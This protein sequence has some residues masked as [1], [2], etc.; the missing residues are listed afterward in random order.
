VSRC[1]NTRADTTYSITFVGAGKQDR[2]DFQAKG[3]RSVEVGRQLKSRRLHHWQVGRLLALRIRPSRVHTDL[4]KRIGQ[5]RA[6]ADRPTRV[7]LA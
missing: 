1:S 2:R 3:F 7:R 5:A 6:V 4:A